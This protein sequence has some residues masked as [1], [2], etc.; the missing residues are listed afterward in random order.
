MK[1]W[2]IERLGMLARGNKCCVSV[3]LYFL[4]PP[5]LIASNALRARIYRAFVAAAKLPRSGF[6]L[7]SRSK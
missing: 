6:I 5:P 3:A 4:V 1:S 7:I 2:M